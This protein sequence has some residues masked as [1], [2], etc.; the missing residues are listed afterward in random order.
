MKGKQLAYR[1]DID[2][3][4]AIAVILVLLFHFNLGVP[5]GFIGVDVFFVISGY[6]ITEVI[7]AACEANRFS[8]A[9]FYAR[10]LIRLHPG[11]I[12]T[13]ALCLGAGYL[14][15]DPAS[16]ASLASSGQ[17]AVF[18]ASNV[19]FWLNSGYFDASAH[20]QPL[21]HTWSLAAEWQFYL[22]WPLVVWASLRVSERFLAVVLVVLAVVSLI[23]SQHMLT[24]DATA[25]Y[26]LMPFRVFELAAGALMVYATKARAGETL[27]S[28][29]LAVGLAIIVASAFLLDSA[30]PFPGL[31]ALPPCVGAAL[32]I[33]AGRSKLGGILRTRPMV[34]VGVISYSVY[35]VHWPIVVFYKYF[36]FREVTVIESIGIFVA[37]ILAGWA[38]YNLVESRFMPGK[39]K[40]NTVRYL[41]SAAMTAAVFA[42][43]WQ[44]VTNGG[45]SQRINQTY[46]SALSNPAEYRTKSYGGFGFNSDGLLG[47]REGLD[48]YLLGDSFSL[49]YASGLDK[50]L[51]PSGIALM[52]LSTNGCFISG[53]Y[54]RL[55][56]NK[57]RSD[58]FIRYRKSMEM[59]ANDKRPLIFALHWTGYRELLATESGERV[60]LKDDKVFA[61]FLTE[62]LHAL[63]K[64]AG[65]RPL[66]IV[67]SQ[68]F[69]SAKKSVAE[70]LLR[71]TFIHQPCNDSIQYNVSQAEAFKTN[72]AIKQAIS[73][74]G[75]TYFIDPSK[76]LCP[77]GMCGPTLDGRLIYSDNTHLSIDGSSV[78]GEQ[79]AKLLEAII[80]G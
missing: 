32:C 10:R 8:F 17:Y 62:N 64:D 1:P 2:G 67:G 34:W 51:A 41:A 42:L 19:F 7:K 71:P 73:S 27:E 43:S 44:V 46:A 69:L 39:V 55:Q 16:F 78:A 40:T 79:I 11:L 54:T 18:A 23:A 33:Y 63:R 56:D 13:V 31:A 30:S 77:N 50:A 61:E 49:Q 20:T 6:L 21:L 74:M 45:F 22:A 47:K 70:C 29:L 5:G 38:M 58:C 3:L 75:N 60:N 65:D 68:P 9:D 4:R 66:I 37:S 48:A 36:V 24:V 26:F 57:P 15:M 52:S 72:E 76:T 35:L 25:S 80:K 28:V 12:T 14:L 53:S 59:M